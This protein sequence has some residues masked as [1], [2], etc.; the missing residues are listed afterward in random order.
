[1]I[2]VNYTIKLRFDDLSDE[3][4]KIVE[5]KLASEGMTMTE[6]FEEGMREILLSEITEDE[7]VE[8]KAEIKE[9]KE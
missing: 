2:E 1:M 7:I 5:A 9:E 3:D 4:K 8:I 6:G